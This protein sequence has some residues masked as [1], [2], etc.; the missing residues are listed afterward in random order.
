M[1]ASVFGFL[2]FAGFEGTTALG[3]ETDNP[4]RDIPHA[5]IYAIVV[6]GILFV[7]SMFAETLGFGATK[8][9]AAHFARSAAPLDV[10]AKEFVGSGLATALSLGA[11]SIAFA[12]ALGAA[13]GASRL[14]FA[15]SRDG[16]GRAPFQRP[17]NTA[18][19]RTRLL[20]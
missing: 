11:T 9:G 20:P 1:A 7:L 13:T 12:S 14:M 15:Y 6:T 3:E 5:L 2:A 4:K 17:P 10:L 18:S 16:W 19:Q 8:A